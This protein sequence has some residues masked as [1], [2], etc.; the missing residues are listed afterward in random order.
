MG[1]TNLLDTVLD[2]SVVLGY[3]KFGSALRQRW[4]PA[5]P[6]PGALTGKR[7]LV[8]GATSGIGEAMVRSFVDLGAV[9]HVH[10][11]NADKLAG[12]ARQLRLDRPAAEIVEEVCDVG[13]LDAVRTWADD[14]MGRVP[15]VH[16]VVHNAGTMT[17]QREES[18]QGHELALA[19]HVLGPHLITELLQDRLA[20]ADGA[21]VVWMSS[22]GMY[23]AR[24]CSDPEDIEFR[25]GDY[26]GVQAYAR[27]KRMQVVLADAWATRLA[28]RDVRVESMHP[29]WV[30]TP[31]V[32]THLP[33]FNRISRPVLRDAEDGADTAVWLVATRPESEPPHFWHDRAQRPVTFGWQSEPDRADVRRFLAYVTQVTGTIPW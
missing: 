2:R 33:T 12:V 5:D 3:S 21:S 18:P 26:K 28:S 13:D 32:A 1:M 6:E 11:R 29:G 4:W 30:E 17:E 7:V 25:R 15:E 22:G 19:V 20:A 31:G 10:G 9:V 24:L 16:G 8:T 14:F 23:G 27:T